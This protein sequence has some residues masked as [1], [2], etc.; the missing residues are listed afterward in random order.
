MAPGMA[1][2]RH[3]LSILTVPCYFLV[4]WTLYRRGL[5]RSYPIFSLCLLVE[6]FVLGA[7]LFP[8]LGHKNVLMVYQ[9]SQ[10]PIWLLYVLA[11]LEIFQK[12][13]AK[14]PGIALFGKRVIWLAILV[15]FVFALS[16]ASGD[17][18]TGWTGSS[19]TKRYTVVVRVASSALTLYMIL[20]SVFLLWMPVPLPRNT[21][22][23][24]VLF[25]F[26]FLITTSLHYVLNTTSGPNVQLVNAGIAGLTIT[27]LAGWLFYLRP[28]GEEIPSFGVAP[29]SSS[30]A[31]LDRLEAVNRALSKR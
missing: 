15:A 22:R 11:V 28:E 2:F 3:F 13:F 10:A 4:V 18:E 9:N 12:V 19:L 27:A 31:M 29:R 16:S 26:Y 23:H 21:I 24:S 14:F 6:G 1:E 25:F 7:M 8:G 17:L 30:S 5:W 20:I